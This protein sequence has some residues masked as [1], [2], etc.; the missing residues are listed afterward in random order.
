MKYIK[1]IC[2]V[3]NKKFNVLKFRIKH[4]RGQTCSNQC[5]YKLHSQRMKTSGNSRWKGGISYH[6]GYKMIHKPTHPHAKGNG[7]VFEHRL[8]VEKSLG[9]YLWPKEVIHH[10]NHN[11]LDNRIE[12][13]EI[14]S[15]SK[16]SKIHA[17]THRK[18]YFCKFC[19]RKHLA[20]HMCVIHYNRWKRK[21]M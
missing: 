2:G 5:R 16:H 18:H 15:K 9:R 21:V 3:C 8:I 4:G 12:N 1:R 11:K 20:R 7:Y 17:P 19:P 14:T 13:L 10:I 6:Q